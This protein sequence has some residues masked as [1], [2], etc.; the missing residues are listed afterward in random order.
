MNDADLGDNVEQYAD[1]ADE[2]NEVTLPRGYL[3][4]NDEAHLEPR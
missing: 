4:E 3:I 2:V 1:Q